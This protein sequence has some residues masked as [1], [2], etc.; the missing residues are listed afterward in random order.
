LTLA[1]DL[2]A[3]EAFLIP[4][5]GNS[6]KRSESDGEVV[7]EGNAGDGSWLVRYDTDN[8]SLL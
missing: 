1:A 3:I 8:Q 6:F 5:T 4:R 7:L 2:V